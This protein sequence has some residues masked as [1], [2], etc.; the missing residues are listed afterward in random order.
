MGRI[1]AMSAL[2][3]KRTYA[4]QQAVS[5][6]SLM[7]T[8][9]ADKTVMSALPPIADVCGAA[10]HVCFGPIADSCTAAKRI[11]I[12]SI[13]QRAGLVYLEF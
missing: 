10:A 7:A 13:R 11:A 9:K 1:A 8:A 4:T 5:A 12:R 2:G 6:L 3:Q